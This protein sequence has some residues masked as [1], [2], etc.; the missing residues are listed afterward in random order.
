MLQKSAPLRVSFGEDQ[1]ENS[2]ML[3]PAVFTLIRSS[4][5]KESHI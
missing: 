3:F 1:R 4:Q 2:G 5:L